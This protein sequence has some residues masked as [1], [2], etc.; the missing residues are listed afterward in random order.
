LA[1]L[2]GK[3]GFLNTKGKVIIPFIYDKALPF[4][5]GGTWVEY[6]NN[7]FAIDQNQQI[8]ATRGDTKSI[9]DLIK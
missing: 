4:H 7:V 9:F 5:N 8:V 1:R 3:Y 2:A 6:Q